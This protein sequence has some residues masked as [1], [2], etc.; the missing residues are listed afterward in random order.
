MFFLFFFSFWRISSSRFRSSIYFSESRRNFLRSI[1][2]NS[3][4]NFL[5]FSGNRPLNR[6]TEFF[7]FFVFFF[8]ETWRIYLFFLSLALHKT[9][10]SQIF[11][12]LWIFFSFQSPFLLF[13][14]SDRISFVKCFH[15]PFSFRFVRDFS[16]LSSI[17]N[18]TVEQILCFVS[19][20]NLRFIFTREKHSL[21]LIH[22]NKAI[23]TKI[24]F[25]R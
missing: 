17:N 11:S 7:F 12:L 1:R 9:K 8:Y 13:A 15:F 4:E 18:K 25:S 24:F 2:W 10:T 22:K 23:R 14:L 20:K 16:R 3:S 5:F 19:P 6:T 21:T